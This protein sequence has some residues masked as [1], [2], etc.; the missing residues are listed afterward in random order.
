MA[1]S[2]ESVLSKGQIESLEI[3]DFIF[4]IINA[5]AEG[6]K[7]IFLDSVTL[8]E[9]QKAFFL[10][11]LK[12]C[13]KGTQ[14]V[15][16]DDVDSLSEKCN[17][18]VAGEKNFV[19]TSK[20]ITQ[21]F[22]KLH[23]GSAADGLFVV[24][25]VRYLRSPNEYKSLLFLVKLDKTATLTYSY[26]EKDGK[27][28]AIINEVPNALSESKQAVQKSALIDL[29]GSFA[30]NVL[31][32]DRVDS[33][34]TDYFRKFLSVKLRQTPSTLTIETHKAVR[35]WA[36]LIPKESLPEG[37]DANTIIG[38]S[39][40]YFESCE[41]FDTDRFL[42]S[43]IRHNDKKVRKV[44]T[45]E[46]HEKL[47]GIGV[48]GQQFKPTPSSIS[49]RDKTV[50]YETAEGVVITF[51]GDAAAAGLT[52]KTLPNGKEQITIETNKFAVKVK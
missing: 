5:D 18:L 15:F 29:S 36:R 47:V 25:V 52:R 8:A 20:D 48:A 43:V 14:Y 44:L 6:D 50:I 40:S 22:A 35:A 4:H 7:T 1:K 49:R 11:R 42:E 33:N 3:S 21:S 31:A 41:T 34:L 32:Y 38:R 13:A 12:E 27:K 28:I 24:S 2:I 45:D 37:E 46:L 30:W 10:N 19:G 9:A 17:K 51:V 23:A 39:I 26:E 16:E